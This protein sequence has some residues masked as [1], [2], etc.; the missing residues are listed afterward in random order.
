VLTLFKIY[1]DRLILPFNFLYTTSVDVCVVP[2]FKFYQHYLTLPFN[3]LYTTSAAAV[4][5]GLRLFNYMRMDVC[6]AP[7]FKFYQHYL[8]FLCIPLPLSLSAAAAALSPRLCDFV[9]AYAFVTNF[10]IL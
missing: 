10:Q 6:V 7:L 8:T 2:L 9:R 5:L 4:A 1:G 3:F